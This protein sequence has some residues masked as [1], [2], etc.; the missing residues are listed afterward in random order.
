MDFRDVYLS[1]RGETVAA[2]AV[3]FLSEKENNYEKQQNEHVHFSP[4]ENKNFVILLKLS[5]HNWHLWWGEEEQ[6]RIAAR[7][8][9][10][11]SSNFS[12]L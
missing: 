6:F 10:D 2:N 3:G 8:G 9:G 4:D 12:V 5:T 11:Y 1:F 7:R